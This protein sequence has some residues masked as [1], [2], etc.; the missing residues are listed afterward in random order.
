ME[1]LEQQD[2]EKLQFLREAWREGLASGDAG[3]VDFPALKREARAP[4]RIEAR[5]SE[6]SP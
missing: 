4:R 5:L 6:E 2:S 1:K 3:E